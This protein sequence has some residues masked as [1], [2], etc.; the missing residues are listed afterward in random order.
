MTTMVP[1]IGHILL[2]ISSVLALFSAILPLIGIKQHNAYLVG[3]SP[4]L[5]R[6]IFISVFFSLLCLIYCFVTDDFSVAYVANHSNSQLA[7]GYKVAA[8]WGSHEGSMLFW[9]FAIALWGAIISYRVKIADCTQDK[10]SDSYQDTLYFARLLAILALVILGFNLFLLFTSNPFARLL[11]NIPIE[12]RDLNPILQDIGLILHPPMLFLGYVGLTV[13][14][15]AALASLLGGGFNTRQINYLRPWVLLAW[16]FLT[17]GNAFGSWWAYNELG[18]GGW[19]FWDPVE[20]ASFI[21]WLV[22]TALVHSLILTQRTHGF[23]LTT[24]LLCLLAFS[25]SLLGS[26]L[27][28]SGI[29]QSV[30][31]FAADPTRGMSI[32]CLLVIFVGAGLLIF[33]LKAHHLKQDVTFALFSKET[34]LLLGIVIL[35]VAAFSVLLGTFYPLIYELLDLGTLSVGAPYFNAIFV[36]LTFLLVLLMGIAPLVQWQKVQWQNASKTRIT[37][38][39]IPSLMIL[40]V[41]GWVSLQAASGSSLFLLLGTAAALWLLVCLLL[42]I[43]VASGLG[44]RVYACQSAP[45]D[46]PVK[47][48]KQ[49]FVAMLFAHFGVAITIIGA[50][51]VSFFEQEA[52]LRM[53]PGQGK[54]LAS[55]V[56]VYES[57]ENVETNSFTA[58]QANI[59]IRDGANDEVLLG[60]VRP[61]RQT[62]KSNGMEMSH[63]G[64]DHGLWRDIYVSMGL[65]L[66]DSEYLIRISYKPLASWI[67]L[68]ALFMMLG[69]AIA[70]WPT[71]RFSSQADLTTLFS[72]SHHKPKETL[73]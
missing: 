21:P 4:V 52:L 12:G 15:A 59:S 29:V 64:I 25:L 28:R 42:T 60:Y 73:A 57:T 19:W 54:P 31:A 35:V 55:Y 70:A 56:L 27:V 61:Q 20:N 2:I 38:L 6:T 40:A 3:L 51:S 14:F 17:G 68:G 50:T 24:L 7:L 16:V 1:E 65:Q 49:G 46:S 11:P 36:P 47:S 66:S 5:F 41:A 8:V 63:A 69:G 34:L 33:A 43:L 13:C 44:R 30:H 53:G 45:N 9:I 26:F 67:W 39:F 72:L 23:K 62:F 37:S 58:I 48:S 18:W 32:L 71:R 10:A 22:A